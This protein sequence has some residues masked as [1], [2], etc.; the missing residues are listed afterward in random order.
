AECGRGDDAWAHIQEALAEFGDDAKLG[1]KCEAAAS[2]VLAARGLADDSRR[3]AAQAEAR[4]PKF[5]GDPGTCRGALY[6]LGIAACPRGD[7]AQGADCWGRYL[8]LGPDPVSQ[9]TALYFRGECRRQLGDVPG[10][11]DDYRAAVA[12]DVDTHYARFAR[13]R[14]AGLPVP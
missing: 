3:R 13:Y 11:E 8:G 12:M 7:H 1:L 10:A 6:D 2:W 5:R 9:P 14:L 4:L